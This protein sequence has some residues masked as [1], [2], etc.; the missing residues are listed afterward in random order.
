MSPGTR[1]PYRAKQA[2]YIVT[3][4]PDYKPQRPW[5]VLPSF[6]SGELYAKNLTMNAAHGIARTFNALALRDH[7]H[8]KWDRR[9]AIV[10]KH[11]KSRRH[12]RH[13]LAAKGGG[14]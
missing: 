4:P 11:L 9:W 2:V 7:C 3:A 14:L 13:P 10:S 5:D 12:G 8:G 1:Q 6:L